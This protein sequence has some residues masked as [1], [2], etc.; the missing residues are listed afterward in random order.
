MEGLSIGG[1]APAQKPSARAP[2]VVW[3]SFPLFSLWIVFSF[4]FG[5]W[6]P[7]GNKQNKKLRKTKN[8]TVKTLAEHKLGKETSE[9]TGFIIRTFSF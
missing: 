4:L 2:V 3:V 1:E 7:K 5:Y 6:Y 9:T 8:E